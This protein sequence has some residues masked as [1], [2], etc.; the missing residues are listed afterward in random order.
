MPITHFSPAPTDATTQSILLVEGY[1]ALAV[2]ISSALK[3]FAPVHTIRVARTLEEAESAATE[4]PPELFVLDLD[5]APTG[6]VDFLVKLQSRC[7]EARV[8]V[9]ASGVSRELRAER[10]TAGAVQFIDKPFDLGEFGAAVQALLGPWA[11]PPSDSFRGTL[12]DLHVVDIVQLKC[13]ALSSAVVR[14]GTPTG[15]AGEIHFYH[16]QIVHAATGRLAGLAALEEIV[17]WRGGRITESKLPEGA[18]K[19]IPDQPWAVLLLAAV[20]KASEHQ[21]AA[22][23]QIAAATPPPPPPP[24]PRKPSKTI[25]A[26]DDTEMLL[27]FA[28]DVLGTAN[29]DFDVVTALTGRE[30]LKLAASIRPDLILLDYSLTDMTGA[31][32]CRGLLMLEATAR[33]PV[34]M[35]SGHLPEL[36][37]T[38]ATYGNVRATLPKPFL[39]GALIDA[40]DK[41]LAAGPL[42]HAPPLPPPP[43]APAPI[44]PPPPPPSAPTLPVPPPV[45]QTEPPTAPPLPIPPQSS[46]APN[47]HGNG[48][49]KSTGPAT[50]SVTFAAPEAQSPLT[51]ILPGVTS[52]PSPPGEIGKDVRVTF[53]LAVM[54]MQLRPD[55]QMDAMQ[56]MPLDAPVGMR[57]ADGGDLSMLVEIGFRMGPMELTPEGRLGT[58]LLIPTSQPPQLAPGS[59][60]FTVD[61]VR[62]R[63]GAQERVVELTAGPTEAMRVHLAARFEFLSVE[64][65]PTFEVVAVILRAREAE[66]LIGPG[67]GS[68]TSPF[69][70]ERAELDE[71]GRLRGLFVK[72]NR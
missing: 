25:L 26:I 3:K 7:P 50:A 35:M 11:M 44:P 64:L 55:F 18:P 48:Q 60:A 57:V 9:I 34:L 22:A 12:R 68:T 51:R 59:N 39:S 36:A 14:L 70:I 49:P 5:P 23:R 46:G 1:D 29:S 52:L 30:G 69:V 45:T 24:T 47:G 27:I 13:L 20:R 2:A 40:V 66:A 37:N 28:A 15:Q 8:L 63:P 62:A 43:I 6:D 16:G 61:A 4:M 17:R 71:T 19:T 41:L 21:K 54:A 65:S 67:G 10:G 33:I 31:D 72:A 42:P 58:M 56:L 32:V 53:A 38:A